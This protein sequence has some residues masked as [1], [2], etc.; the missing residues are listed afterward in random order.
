MENLSG[1]GLEEDP[2]LAELQT[3]QAYEPIRGGD[4]LGHQGNL[5]G[6]RNGNGDGI[7]GFEGNNSVFCFLVDFFGS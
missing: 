5:D 2:L 3:V 1:K 7:A 4:Q 6:N